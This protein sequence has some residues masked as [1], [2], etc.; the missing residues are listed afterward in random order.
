MQK[1]R[2]EM[3]NLD[4]ELGNVKANVQMNRTKLQDHETRIDSLETFH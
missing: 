2:R 4:Q 1:L 3:R